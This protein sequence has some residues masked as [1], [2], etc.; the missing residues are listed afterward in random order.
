M[1]QRSRSAEHAT[2][3]AC[4]AS[5]PNL[6]AS[7]GPWRGQPCIWQRFRT[8]HQPPVSRSKPTRAAHGGLS[9]STTQ[10]A[11]YYRERPF[12]AVRECGFR[13][14]APERELT[15]GRR[16]SLGPEVAF[17]GRMRMKSLLVL[18][19]LLISEGC[20]HDRPAMSSGSVGCAP[21]R[22]A[23]SEE[24][25]GWSTDTWAATCDGQKFWCSYSTTLAGRGGTIACSPVS[26][27]P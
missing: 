3:R 20:G 17:I 25:S 6:P 7:T 22:I 23:V 10:E 26:K 8:R 18:V 9:R 1:R 12:A 16:P 14:R 4:R 27:R 5:A 11:K 15:R 2:E 19:L 21:D 24:H 13:T